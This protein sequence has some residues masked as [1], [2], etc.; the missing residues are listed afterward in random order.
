MVY[1]EKTVQR[2]PR[3]LFSD[4]DTPSSESEWHKRTRKKQ[5]SDTQ[6]FS[7]YI[8]GG[9]RGPATAADDSWPA[10]WCPGC[11]GRKPNKRS[12]K[13]VPVRAR[14]ELFTAA[15]T[16]VHFAT[17]AMNG[18]GAARTT[19][20][21]EVPLSAYLPAPA[22][23]GPLHLAFVARGR[24]MRT[25]GDSGR[26]GF[27][28]DLRP[29]R[30]CARDACTWGHKAHFLKKWNSVFGFY[31]LKGAQS[32]W[33]GRDCFLSVFGLKGSGRWKRFIDLLGGHLVFIEME[34]KGRRRMGSDVTW[35]AATAFSF[36][37]SERGAHMCEW[38]WLRGVLAHWWGGK[39]LCHVTLVILLVP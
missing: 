37:F 1:I 15:V 28:P 21:S 19:R 26:S 23:N 10:A 6:G 12:C 5:P 14:W 8:C 29:L 33:G 38:K 17:G 3:K 36:T 39:K 9:G 18:N 31:H 11:T 2:F 13:Y 4:L 16:C 34:R 7:T 25:Q 27:W 30:F 32:L 20:A 24:R 22:M 35:H